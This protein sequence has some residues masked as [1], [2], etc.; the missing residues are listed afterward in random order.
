MASER[1]PRLPYIARQIRVTRLVDL[2]SR[3]VIT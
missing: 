2:E 1:P 3:L